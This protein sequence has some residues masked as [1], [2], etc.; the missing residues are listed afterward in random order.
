MEIWREN[1]SLKGLEFARAAQALAVAGKGEAP[2][3]AASRWGRESK[4]YSVTKTAV[5][6]NS[7]SNQTGLS[8]DYRQAAS[9][10]LELVRNESIIGQMARLRRVP[11]QVPYLKQT[12]SAE[13]NWVGEGQPAPIANGLFTRSSLELEKLIA[14][15]VTT[16]ELLKEPDADRA[17]RD[18]LVAACAESLDSAFI[19]P[20]NA[21]TTDVKPASIT[22]GVSALTATGTMSLDIERMVSIFGGDLKRAVFIGKPQLFT[23]LYGADYP[24]VGARGGEL[25]G[26][27]A[28]ASNGLPNS[29]GDDYQLALVDPAAIAYAGLT[30]ARLKATEQGT[31]EMTDAPTQDAPTGS[32]LV[33]LWQSGLV[34]IAAQID[35]NWERQRDDAVVV[36]E[37]VAGAETST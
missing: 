26:I 10:F 27:P 34:A 14:M 16:K 17:L 22:N 32:S 28:I 3:W 8:G 25:A 29:A 12:E 20:A 30:T 6:A 13:A 1:V 24:N 9:D 18:D 33:G 23:K 21:G 2:E 4:T 19:D 35:A 31:I 36:L 11:A 37:G 15:T 5:A 7:T